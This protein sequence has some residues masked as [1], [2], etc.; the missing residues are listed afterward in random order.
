MIISE[1]RVSHGLGGSVAMQRERDMDGLHYDRICRTD[2]SEAYLISQSDEPLARVDL[3]FTSS[4]VYGLLIVER[5]MTQEETMELI[6]TIDEDLVWSADLPRDDFVVT[7]Y[8][9]QEVGVFSDP[10]FEDDEDEENGVAR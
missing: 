9:G 6:E 7:V 10:R 4:I 2:R 3:H 8:Q 1:P 5:D